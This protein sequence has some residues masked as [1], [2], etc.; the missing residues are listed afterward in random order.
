MRA[1][2]LMRFALRS[3]SPGRCAARGLPMNEIH[4]RFPVLK[5]LENGAFS[6]LLGLKVE[7][8]S[9]GSVAVRMPFHLRLL[10]EGPPDVPIHGGAI[11]SLADFAACA[12]VWTLPGA[13]SSATISM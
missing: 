12:A 6:A 9:E 13:R 5:G 2:L 11:A 4:R 10:N 7:S 1:T 3:S 8:A